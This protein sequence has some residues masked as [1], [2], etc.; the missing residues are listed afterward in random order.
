M[1][2]GVGNVIGQV[3]QQLG[4]ATPGST[5]L[6]NAANS[7]VTSGMG[8]KGGVAQPNTWMGD[9]P[10]MTGA[11]IQ[12]PIGSG[13]KGGVGTAVPGPIMASPMA[14]PQPAPGA[15]GKGGIGA[16]TQPHPHDMGASVSSN[17]QKLFAQQLGNKGRAQP[18]PFQKPQP[19]PMPQPRLG[20]LGGL[21]KGQPTPVQAANGRASVMSPQNNL[22]QNNGILFGA[23]GQPVYSQQADTAHVGNIFGAGQPQPMTGAAVDPSFQSLYPGVNPNAGTPVNLSTFG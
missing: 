22:N 6:N 12:Q 2:S 1:G 20:G 16:A 17:L 18:V 19:A 11:P 4:Q 21:L 13:G 9:A 7:P 15:G 5:D 8:G 10:N 23:N 3:G 14:N